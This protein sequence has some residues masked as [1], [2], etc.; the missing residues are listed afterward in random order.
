VATEDPGNTAT[1]YLDA[2]TARPLQIIFTV[3][4]SH[5]LLGK[6]TFLLTV[7]YQETPAGAWLPHRTVFDQTF[8]VLLLKRRI[9]IESEYRD[10]RPS[11][12]APGT[13]T[14]AS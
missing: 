12:A 4:F 14:P 11:T 13:P 1:A 5:L 2:A 7:E 8:R 3:P 9:H 10:W 6:S